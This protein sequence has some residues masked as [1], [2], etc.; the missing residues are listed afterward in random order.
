MTRTQVKKAYN[1]LVRWQNSAVPGF[2]PSVYPTVVQQRFCLLVHETNLII[3]ARAKAKIVNEQHALRYRALLQRGVIVE[4]RNGIRFRKNVFGAFRFWL[5]RW[6]PS[7]T[8]A[9]QL[10]FSCR[11]GFENVAAQYESHWLRFNS[12][13]EHQFPFSLLYL[14]SGR[15]REVISVSFRQYADFSFGYSRIPQA[16][17][18]LAYNDLGVISGAI[19]RR[20]RPKLL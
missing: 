13:P 18:E 14:L 6:S 11:R 4:G 16:E 3:L 1:R 19:V 17:L 15:T 10:F 2:S 20:R 5:Q 12:M 7:N 9:G 8:L